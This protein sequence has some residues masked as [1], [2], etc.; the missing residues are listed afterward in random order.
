MIFVDKA[1]K[2]NLGET[3]KD[4]AL[5][6]TSMEGEVFGCLRPKYLI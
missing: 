2:K 3:T 1:K 5:L 4:F 6:L